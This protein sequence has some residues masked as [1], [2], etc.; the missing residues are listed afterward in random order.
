MVQLRTTV[1]KEPDSRSVGI[2]MDYKLIAGVQARWRAI[3]A[4]YLVVPYEPGL[5]QANNSND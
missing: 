2:A 4:P 5:P 3:N 1:T